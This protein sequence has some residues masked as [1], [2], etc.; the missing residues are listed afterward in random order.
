MRN[1]CGSSR[2]VDGVEV[3]RDSLRAIDA[4]RQQGH[5]RQTA[6][7]R[8]DGGGASSERSL[9]QET[10]SVKHN[11][12]FGRPNRRDAAPRAWSKAFESFASP[13]T[14]FFKGP[15]LCGADAAS[16]R[17]YAAAT[18][19]KRLR[20]RSKSVNRNVSTNPSSI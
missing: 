10:K 11:T 15:R 13:S 16:P 6:K 4:T 2:R 9:L 3:E 20:N 1:L 7:K 18:K 5:G 14:V 19:A 12:R 17:A 8:Q